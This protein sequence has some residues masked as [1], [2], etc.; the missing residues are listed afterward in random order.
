M[1]RLVG[2]ACR[3][4][5]YSDLTVKSDQQKIEKLILESAKAHWSYAKNKESMPKIS[6]SK[7]LCNALHFESSER[8]VIRE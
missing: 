3:D 5:I 8:G 6:L 7:H 1:Q 4:T 2:H